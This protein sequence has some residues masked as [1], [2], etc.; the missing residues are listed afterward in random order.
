M[1]S[2]L[3]PHGPVVDE[4]R[5]SLGIYYTPNDA[6]KLLAEWA[7]R[8]PLDSVLE[9]SFGGCSFLAA[10]KERLEALGAPTP[11][12]QMF[13]YDVDPEAFVYLAKTLTAQPTANF[14]LQDFLKSRCTSKDPQVTTAL[15]NPPFV[16]YHRMNRHQRAVLD[17]WRTENGA[18][19]PKSASL[20]AYFLIHS[21]TFLAP[22]GRLAFILPSAFCT[23][24]YA[25]PISDYLTRVFRRVLVFAVRD[26]LFLQAGARE[27][28]VVLLAEGFRPDADAGSVKAEVHAVCT[29]EELSRTIHATAQSGESRRID[30]APAALDD[31]SSEDAF[32]ELGEF[33][34]ITI[35]EVVGDTEFFV[36]SARAWNTLGIP[37]RYLYPI[38][39]KGRQLP[40]VL[41][42][43]SDIKGNY[44]VVPL[45]LRAEGKSF[46][47][48]VSKYL[49]LYPARTRTANRTFQKRDPWHLTSYRTDAAAFIGSLSQ[50]APRIV[51]NHAKISCANG[52]YQLRPLRGMRWN[53]AVAVA[54][55][56][57]VCQLSAERTARTR[58]P[59]ALKLEPSDAK[60][61]LIP[62]TALEMSSSDARRLAS[63]VDRI[64]RQHGFAAAARHVDYSLLLEPNVLTHRELAKLQDEVRRLRSLRLAKT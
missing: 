1:S 57:T 28:T 43:K 33:A 29:L 32:F 24:D 48:A 56:S 26:Q 8:T 19:F 35:G 17:T 64:Y 55:L 4:R 16:S 46:P 49:D 13:G 11:A 41:L 21:L 54:S 10:A 20:W 42:K 58:G 50:I 39:T 53:P 62:S 30:F 34:S 38:A 27:R 47:R 12:R 25:K 6:A 9:P 37:P 18:F 51:L 40:G 59:G 63:E 45:L 15:G 52:L 31:I 60:R 36:K 7:I 61:L 23:A 44:S 2:A 22:Q 14:R 5:R 3:S